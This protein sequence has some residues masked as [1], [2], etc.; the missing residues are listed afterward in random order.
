MKRHDHPSL[1]AFTIS[2]A[3]LCGGTHG[4]ELT[5]VTAVRRRTAAAATSATAAVPGWDDTYL[6]APRSAETF[7]LE[8]VIANPGAVAINRRYVDFDLNRCF[9]ATDL[10][11]PHQTAYEHQRAQV[12][13]AL[14]G[15]KGAPDP[16]AQF[17]IDL[18]TTTADLGPTVIIREDDAFARVCAAAVQHSLPDTRI[19]SYYTT[20]DDRADAPVGGG[21]GSAGA[22]GDYPFLAEIT[23]S[24][25]EIEVGP[26]PQGVIRADVL[27]QTEAIINEIVATLDRW[28]RDEAF[29]VAPTIDVYRYVGDSDFP[30]DTAGAIAGMIHPER[31]DRDF[32]PLAPGDPLYLTFAGETVHWDG[33]ETV[34]P[35]F[36]NEAAYYE[37]RAALTLCEKRTVSVV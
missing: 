4:N 6:P 9:S 35:V 12:L 22:S 18:H 32:E 23:P 25:I 13:N 16:R 14:F 20:T 7:A 5:G 10:A 8:A 27:I 17:L 33:P 37:K 34:Y 1:A 28:N 3:G 21:P 2:R 29:P 24:G 15:P 11:R 31:Q 30:R 19:M 26:V 36:V